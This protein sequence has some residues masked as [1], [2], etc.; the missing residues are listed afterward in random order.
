M[1]GAEFTIPFIHHLLICFFQTRKKNE[2]RK[3]SGLQHLRLQFIIWQINSKKLCKHAEFCISVKWVFNPY[4]QRD[5]EQ[6]I[7]E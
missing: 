5:V 3:N 7:D 6:F 1:P 2:T 4:Q